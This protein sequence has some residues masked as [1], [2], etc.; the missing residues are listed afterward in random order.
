MLLFLIY[1]VAHTLSS[2]V[3]FNIGPSFWTLLQ[4]ERHHF[5]A[6]SSVEFFF[7]TV[8]QVFLV[9]IGRHAQNIF[10]KRD[11]RKFCANERSGVYVE[12]WHCVVE[13]GF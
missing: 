5:S 1:S 7:Y 4:P 9:L 3:D 12:I 11:R 8:N 2:G 13:Y 6:R 10:Q